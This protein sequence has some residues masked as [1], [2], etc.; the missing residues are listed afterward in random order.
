MLSVV[1][2]SINLQSWLPV[3]LYVICVSSLTDVVHTNF[4]SQS[5]IYMEKAFHHD[6]EIY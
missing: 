2:I 1:F 5:N 3:G 4:Y 6:V